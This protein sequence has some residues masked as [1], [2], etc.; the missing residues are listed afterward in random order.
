MP[1]HPTATT[2]AAAIRLRQ[3]RP[4]AN[5]Q[6]RPGANRNVRESATSDAI[7]DALSAAF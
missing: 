4:D 5:R 1:P 2:T 3:A 6:A 7:G